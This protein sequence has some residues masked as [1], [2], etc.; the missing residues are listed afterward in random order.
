MP[1]TN[2]NLKL[3]HGCDL[4][5]AVL[6]MN[7]TLSHNHSIDLSLGS[8][9]ADFGRGFY[10][11]TN[12]SQAKNWANV[13]WLRNQQIG[14]ATVLRFDVDRYLLTQLQTLCFVT[15]N[16]N[17]DY[18][19]LVKDCRQGMIISHALAGQYNY[20]M[21]LGPVAL[22]NQTLVIKDCDQMSFHTSKGLAILPTPTIEAQG[23][24]FF[25]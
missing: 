17:P 15:E 6:I 25:P 2:A 1:W 16:S 20:D 21:I 14:I 3:Y 5:S 13:R 12:F 22:P 8:S 10:M 19:D 23:T 11:T 24:P 4:S 7:P 9:L 18:W